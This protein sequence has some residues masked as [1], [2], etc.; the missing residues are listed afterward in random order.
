MKK[1]TLQ[2]CLAIGLAIG[3]VVSGQAQMAAEYRA[4]IPFD[5]SVGGAEFKAGDYFIGM[6]NPQSSG[7]TLT[8][9]EASG[10]RSKLFLTLPE[11]TNMRLEPAKIIFSRYENQY[12]LSEITTPACGAKFIQSKTEHNLARNQKTN[13]ETIAILK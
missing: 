3:F 11:D 10:R 5:F 9:R 1:I 6:T 12:F 2:I 4:H 8:I 13:R 7:Q